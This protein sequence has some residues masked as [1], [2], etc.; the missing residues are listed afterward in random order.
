M[1][2]PDLPQGAATVRKT[3][4]VP[5]KDAASGKEGTGQAAATP[6]MRVIADSLKGR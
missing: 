1:T 6:G 4:V 3:A 2:I 5:G